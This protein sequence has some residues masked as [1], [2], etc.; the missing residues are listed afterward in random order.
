MTLRIGTGR[1]A[2]LVRH[3]AGSA[4]PP[5]SF[6]RGGAARCRASAVVPALAPP[7]L[8]VAALGYARRPR[9]VGMKR[10]VVARAVAAETE[11]VRAA[12]EGDT[13]RVHYKGSLEDGTVFDSSEGRA[14]LSFTLGRQQVVPGFEAAV[15]GLR[16]GDRVS[17][18]L[19]PEQA[20][21][22]RNEGLVITIPAAQAPSGLEVGMQVRMS[23]SSGRAVPAT[24]VE[25]AEDGAVKVDANPR[26]AGKTLLFD[27]ELVGFKEFLAP[28]KPPEGMEL[29]TFAAGCFWGVELAFQR[30]RGVVATSVGYCQGEMERPTYE[31]VCGAGTGHTEGVRVVYNPR[32]VSFK[33]L[34]ETFWERVGRNATTLN[35]AGND[36]GPQYRSGVYFHSEE[37]R[38]QGEES[39]RA[40]EQRLGEKV[41][42]EVEKAAPFW[43]AED[44]HQQYL[45]NG[46]RNNNPQSAAKGCTDTIRCYG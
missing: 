20:Y 39:V 3:I 46:G 1:A 38:L 31:D 23:S 8:G 35:R 42:T 43:L 6:Q 10:G 2:A 28:E 13:V 16:P 30:V 19:A 29:A 7:V 12:V 41:V 32:E 36:E 44:Y 4:L 33:D 17:V 26:L 11:A 24:V 14:P 40:L 27:I 18:K 15:A 25:L 5:A 9:G 37:Q 45:A 34:L 22:D 21:G